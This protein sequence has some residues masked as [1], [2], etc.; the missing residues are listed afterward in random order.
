ML[1]FCWFPYCSWVSLPFLQAKNLHQGF[2]LKPPRS[3]NSTETFRRGEGL[4]MSLNVAYIPE[5]SSQGSTSQGPLDSSAEKI[6]EKMGVR[7][8]GTAPEKMLRFSHRKIWFSTENHDVHDRKINI[9]WSFFFSTNIVFSRDFGLQKTLAY[10][11]QR[12]FFL[13]FFFSQTMFRKVEPWSPEKRKGGVDLDPGPCFQRFSVWGAFVLKETCQW[14]EGRRGEGVQAKPGLFVFQ[15][16]FRIS[17]A[18]W[19]G[20]VTGLTKNGIR[21]G[22]DKACENHRSWVENWFFSLQWTS[23]FF[24]LKCNL[25]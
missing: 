6:F 4:L 24:K 5:C 14:V 8:R 1:S 15:L 19:L 23:C 13:L 11:P 22:R 3:L 10:K 16:C 20:Y 2:T 18:I 25:G 21:R 9:S 7:E 12:K 17:K